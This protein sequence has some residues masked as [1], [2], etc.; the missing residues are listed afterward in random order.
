MKY[1]GSGGTSIV[2]VVPT[3][4]KMPELLLHGCFYHYLTTDPVIANATHPDL[5]GLRST[6]LEEAV[7]E[8]SSYAIR[9]TYGPRID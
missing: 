7:K 9:I 1:P 3:H 6:D 4:L 2:V 5:G 8:N